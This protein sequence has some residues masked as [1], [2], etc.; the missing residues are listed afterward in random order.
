MFVEGTLNY[1]QRITYTFFVGPFHCAWCHTSRE[2]RVREGS[3]W[4]A[5][6]QLAQHEWLSLCV[7]PLAEH[8]ECS[9][10]TAHKSKQ[11]FLA[12]GDGSGGY[13]NLRSMVCDISLGENLETGSMRWDLLILVVKGRFYTFKPP[14]S[15]AGSTPY[16]ADESHSR[17]TIAHVLF[18]IWDRRDCS[19]NLQHTDVLAWR[20]DTASWNSKK[21]ITVRRFSGKLFIYKS[22]CWEPPVNTHGTRS[23]LHERRSGRRN[24]RVGK[25]EKAAYWFKNLP[26]HRYEKS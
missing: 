18:V 2:Q 5:S 21:K 3:E 9:L 6:Q 20:K 14:A 22:S 10:K 8:P 4:A 17:G 12:I 25:N 7:F 26:N 16:P 15:G 23:K 11:A 19:Q 13:P 1:Q 24:T